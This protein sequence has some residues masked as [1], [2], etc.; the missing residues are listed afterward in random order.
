[1]AKYRIVSK[2]NIVTIKSKLSFGEQT[3]TGRKKDDYLYGAECD[4]A[5]IIFEKRNRKRS[6][7][8]D[9]CT[10]N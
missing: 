3:E 4:S 2:G 7:L 9:Y 10:D 1:M 8:S 6:F 5:Y